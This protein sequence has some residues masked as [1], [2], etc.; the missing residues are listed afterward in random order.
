MRCFPNEGLAT[1]YAHQVIDHAV[2]Y[3]DGKIHRNGKGLIALRPIQNVKRYSRNYAFDKPKYNALF[4][5]ANF[6]ASKRIQLTIP[7]KYN[8]HL[9]TK[10][11]LRTHILVTWQA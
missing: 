4:P 9:I 8:G 2:K 1:E 11:G 6:R 10:L 5:R 7:G 3:V